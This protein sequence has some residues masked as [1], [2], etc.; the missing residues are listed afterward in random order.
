MIM[1][2]RYFMDLDNRGIAKSQCTNIVFPS[3]FS[4]QKELEQKMIEEETAK[5]V[6]ALVEKRVQEELEKRKADI[7][8]EVKCF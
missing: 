2:P 7:E 6:E 1:A 4:R 8:K 3:C 5:R